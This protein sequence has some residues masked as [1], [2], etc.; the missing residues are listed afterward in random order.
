M[1]ATNA[2]KLG[3]AHRGERVSRKQK[4]K[5]AHWFP[6]PRNAGFDSHLDRSP[7]AV[8]RVSWRSFLLMRKSFSTP[9]STQT[10][11]RIIRGEIAVCTLATWIP[12]RGC[13][14]RRSTIGP[15]VISPA[16]WQGSGLH[17]GTALGDAGRGDAKKLSSNLAIGD[18]ALN[19][20]PPRQPP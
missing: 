20:K 12:P 13:I 1:H 2:E 7:I 17:H 5:K 14:D 6:M 10:R 16:A 4:K 8:L 11:S 19:R 18:T 9:P 3:F 15:S